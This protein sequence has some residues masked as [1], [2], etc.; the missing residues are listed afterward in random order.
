MGNVADCAGTRVGQLSL[1]IEIAISG[2]KVVSLR[3]LGVAVLPTVYA[4]FPGNWLAALVVASGVGILVG[5]TLS[6]EPLVAMTM[7]LCGWIAAA[8]MHRATQ[9][10]VAF[11]VLLAVVL[12][13]VVG[14]A[15]SFQPVFV[16]LAANVGVLLAAGLRGPVQREDVGLVLLL[17]AVLWPYLVGGSLGTLPGALGIVVITYAT[18]RF[19]GVSLPLFLT[20]LLLAGAIQGV[21]AI[22][23]SLPSLSSLVPFQPLVGGVPFD[24]GRA[25]GLFNNPN[26]LGALEAV[27]LVIAVRVG[28][29]RWAL[30]L[31]ALCAAG[32]ILSSS[33]EAVFGLIVGLSLL[34]TGRFR[35]MVAWAIVLLVVGAMTV[36]A[37]PSLLERLSPSGYATDPNLLGRLDLWRAGLDLIKMSPL[38]GYGADVFRSGTVTDNAYVGWLLAGGIVGLVLWIVASTVATPRQLWPVLAAMFAIA[39]LGNPFSGPTYTVFLATCGAVAAENARQRPCLTGAVASEA[40][41]L[42]VAET[43]RSNGGAAN[44]S[45]C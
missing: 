10:A 4:R 32:L 43:R 31:V 22:A 6:V 7:L 8:M 2:P 3:R 30:P 27:V 18:G 9:Y 12:P 24:F 21:V 44:A 39:V 19:R 37:F 13:D 38:L 23:Q 20:L 1:G 33:R 25:T 45:G 34:G 36:W 41:S 35:Q 40:A 26:T 11:N 28:P 14:N 17:A 5:S 15:L 29:R 16:L 42:S